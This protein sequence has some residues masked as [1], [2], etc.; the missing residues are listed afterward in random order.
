[1][2]EPLSPHNDCPCGPCTVFR[3]VETTLVGFGAA[4]QVRV[5]DA[6]EASLV[7]AVRETHP[8]ACTCNYCQRLNEKAREQ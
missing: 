3:S 1:M 5:L 2:N 7:Q 8:I 6:L 4:R